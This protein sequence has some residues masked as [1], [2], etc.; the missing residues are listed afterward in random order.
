MTRKA[1]LPGLALAVIYS[2]LTENVRPLMLK[3]LKSMLL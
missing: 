1:R 2:V 3:P